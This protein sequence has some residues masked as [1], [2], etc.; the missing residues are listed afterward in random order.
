MDNVS[1]E[2]LSKT[3]LSPFE[4]S[5]TVLYRF[6]DLRSVNSPACY[7]QNRRIAS[8]SDAAEG[9]ILPNDSCFPGR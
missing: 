6:A 4:S 7:H 3:L 2:F 5:C 9:F 8:L 1:L